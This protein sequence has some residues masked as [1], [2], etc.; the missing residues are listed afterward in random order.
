[1]YGIA[2]DAPFGGYHSWMIRQFVFV[3]AVGGACH[4]P[5]QT[6]PATSLDDFRAH[7]ERLRADGHIQAISASSRRSG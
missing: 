7:L 1:L 6:K 3:L 4:L 2:L 5:T